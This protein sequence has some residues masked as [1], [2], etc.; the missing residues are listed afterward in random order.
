MRAE[1]RAESL[2]RNSQ[3]TRRWGVILA[4]GDGKRLLPLTQKI[5]GDDRP[6]CNVMGRHTLLSQT[7]SRISRIIHRDRTSLA[8]TKP[9]ERFYADEVATVS[10]ARLL[11]QPHNRGTAPAIGARR[12]SRFWEIPS[13]AMDHTAFCPRVAEFRHRDF[14]RTSWRKHGA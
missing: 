6:K 1:P 2:R 9:H 13:Q 3:H 14:L 8:L 12:V 7:R 11:E 10:S 5:T 4:G